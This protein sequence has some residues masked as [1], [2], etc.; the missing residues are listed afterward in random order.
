[1][2][3]LYPWQ[4][5]IWQQHMPTAVQRHH[6]LLIRGPRGVGKRR[7]AE[8]IAQSV[9]CRTPGAHA[10]PCGQCQA[11]NW[12]AQAQHPDFLVVEPRVDSEGEGEG[13][14]APAKKSPPQ[15]K[16]DQIRATVSALALS[17]H[18]GGRR[19]VLVEPAESMNAHAA[20]A[21]LKTLEEPTPGTLFLLVNHRRGLLPAT[22]VS[23]CRALDV[24]LPPQSQASAWLRTH[25]ADQ[26]VQDAEATEAALA[27]A[28]GAPLLA[29]EKAAPEARARLATILTALKQGAAV[30]PIAQAER[31]MHFSAAEIV[32]SMQTW[33]HDLLARKLGH[34]ATYHVDCAESQAHATAH[35]RVQDLLALQRKLLDA[36]RLAGHPLN[37]RL[38]AEELL[39]AYRSACG[40]RT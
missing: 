40:G 13:S 3:A 36:K 12:I 14:A 6:A 23:R 31:W 37:T 25:C 9:L 7:L 34:E 27:L 19:V 15:I 38:V 1:M 4:Q 24:A 18:Q 11:C 2:S 35:A 32:E 28:G 16:I 39:L 30:D 22:I 33:N 10:L 17:T 20:N 5:S 29:L 26:G 8:V 21:L